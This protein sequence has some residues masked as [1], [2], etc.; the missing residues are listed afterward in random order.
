MDLLSFKK[1]RLRGYLIAVYSYLMGESRKDRDRLFSEIYSGRLKSNRQKL[2][3]KTFSLDI[4]MI[5]FS[6]ESDHILEQ[7]TLRGCGLC[8]LADI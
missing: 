4:R 2:E 7:V 8:L 1:R 5:F 6:H 3:Y